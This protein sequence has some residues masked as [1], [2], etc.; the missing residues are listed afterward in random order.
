MTQAQHLAL[1]NLIPLT[2]TH[3]FSPP[4][5]LY[6]ASLPLSSPAHVLLSPRLYAYVNEKLFSKPTYASFIRLLDNY[7]RA[8]GREE[9]VTAEELQEQ[10]VFLREVMKTELMKKLFAFLHQKSERW[11]KAGA[12]RDGVRVLIQQLL[13]SAYRSLRLRGGIPAGSEGDVVW[14]LL[15]R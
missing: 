3:G 15:P 12:G 14:A 4:G 10:N 5:P 9:E 11:I 13:P 7:Q 1:L 8:T 2:S 6:R